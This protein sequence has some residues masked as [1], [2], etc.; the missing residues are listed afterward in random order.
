MAILGVLPA[1][2]VILPETVARSL[3]PA[4][5]PWPSIALGLMAGAALG[6]V[7]AFWP[8]LRAK[9]I[10]VAISLTA[11]GFIWA[12]ITLFPV[13]D[14]AASARALWAASRPD[15]A[16]VLARGMADGLYYYSEKQLPD[17][18]IVDKNATPFSGNKRTH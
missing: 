4:Q 12:E 18:A 17:C 7:F 16:P 10:I 13:L 14:K 11:A 8:L 15:C 3:K 9:A 1:A 5:I 6:V 2:G